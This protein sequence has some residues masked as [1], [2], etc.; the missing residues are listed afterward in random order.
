MNLISDKER[1]LEEAHRETREAV[2]AARAALGYT[3]PSP[4][5]DEVIDFAAVDEEGRRGAYVLPFL[6]RSVIEI[7][8]RAALL[9][10]RYP[11]ALLSET[12]RAALDLMLGT[13]TR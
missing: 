9:A 2:E 11:E 3:E 8:D 10:R 5:A 7:V 6:P 4:E 13:V 12:H 1:S